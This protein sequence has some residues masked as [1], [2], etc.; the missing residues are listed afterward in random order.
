ME[1]KTSLW[2]MGQAVS[3]AIGVSAIFEYGF[4]VGLAVG[5]AL[6]V[7]VDIR[8]EVQSLNV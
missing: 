2:W 5:Y 3:T 6:Q 4:V 7:L 1:K 8:E